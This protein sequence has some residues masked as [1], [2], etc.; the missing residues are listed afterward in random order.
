MLENQIPVEPVTPLMR[1]NNE[2]HNL[3]F[4]TF[5]PEFDIFA[6][7]QKV[8]KETVLFNVVKPIFTYKDINKFLKS[9]K[10]QDYVNEIR[11]G[12]TMNENALYHCVKLNFLAKKILKIHI[13]YIFLAK[14]ILK[15]LIKLNLF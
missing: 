15:Y 7:A 2:L 5:G 4:H 6:Y 9:S 3:K 11:I 12:Y 1:P 8:E 13:F 14:K 10:I